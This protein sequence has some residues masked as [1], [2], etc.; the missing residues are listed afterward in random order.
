MTETPTSAE[1]QPGLKQVFR[2]RFLSFDP[3]SLGLFRLFF[4]SV[5]L[6]DL[7]RRAPSWVHFYTNEGLLPNHLLLWRPQSRN[8]LSA[9]FLA[10]SEA[11]A[12]VGFALCL[13]V[14]LGFLAGFRTKVFQ[15]LAFA[16]VV[17]LH[18]RNVITENGGDIVMNLLAAW[19]LFLPLGQRFSID[20]LLSRGRLQA[21]PPPVTLAC[22]AIVLQ[23]ATI[24]FFNTVQKGGLT[25][26]E[27]TSIHYVFHQDR[28]VTWLAWAIREHVPAIVTKLL[29]WGTVVVEGS[30]VVLLLTPWATVRA[31]R[32]FVVA[33]A[34]LHLGIAA[35]MNVGMFSWAM[36]S[37][38]PLLLGPEDWA[39][40]SRRLPG[41]A[42]RLGRLLGVDPTPAPPEPP[43]EPWRLTARRGLGWVREGAVVVLMIAVTFQVL[44]ENKAVPQWLKPP[45]PA[46]LA[47][48]VGWGRLMQGWFMFAPNAPREDGCLVVDA[49]TMSGK[50][51]DPFN[52][53][54][55]GWKGEPFDR[56]PD[57][58]GL[59]HSW[60]SYS[61]R[62]HEDRNR[63]Y[64]DALKQW[65]L[66]FPERT[67]DP[68]DRIV[69]FEALWVTDKSP[70]IGAHQPTGHAKRSVLAHGRAASAP[71][72]K[73]EEKP[74]SKPGDAERPHDELVPTMPLSA[75]PE[76]G[77]AEEAHE[78]TGRP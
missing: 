50:R 13:V 22:F 65:I 44:N 56:V 52:W 68:K 60:R 78:D 48:L 42:A 7:L 36:I 70:P 10:S 20:A 17:S 2:E 49:L 8:V 34:S 45:T 53:E 27:G 61:A 28:V 37:F 74:A 25:W 33:L 55:I 67:G 43:P 15:L 1:A 6:V 62:I 51:V 5:L 31:R 14:Y 72:R 18:T 21:R 23:L 19:T 73:A 47:K 9:F 3:R 35:T 63:V 32:V 4:G 59:D 75:A 64:R 12:W 11:E 71:T 66:R 26:R 58:L 57:R 41:L 29:T 16:C 40:F 39:L 46:P 76:D 54:A 77:P 30:A 24:Y 38:Y 69:S